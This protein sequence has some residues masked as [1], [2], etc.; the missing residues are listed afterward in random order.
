MQCPCPRHLLLSCKKSSC[1]EISFGRSITF[2]AKLA[3]L[4]SALCEKTYNMC[5][6]PRACSTTSTSRST[7]LLAKKPRTHDG[8]ILWPCTHDFSIPLPHYAGTPSH[9]VGKLQT[10]VPCLFLQEIDSVIF[11]TWFRKAIVSILSQ[12]KYDLLLLLCYPTFI[13]QEGREL[14]SLQS[15][16]M[17]SF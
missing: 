3:L 5:A 9:H 7:K 11:S 17:M 10:P 4:P 2:A 14:A 6:T 12:H 1:L 13:V 8:K 15:T 16:D